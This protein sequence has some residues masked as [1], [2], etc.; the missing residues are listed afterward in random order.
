MGCAITKSKSVPIALSLTISRSDINSSFSSQ[1][2]R[3]K[4]NILPRSSKDFWGT[5]PYYVL[6]NRLCHLFNEVKSKF[7]FQKIL[8]SV[9]MILN[10]V[11]EYFDDNEKEV[12]LDEFGSTWVSKYENSEFLLRIL[13]LEVDGKRVYVMEG[14]N[15]SHVLVKIKEIGYF[16]RKASASE[17]QNLTFS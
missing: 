12:K 10:D 11:L 8:T 1:S 5:N 15:R 7:T 2:L 6:S 14:V 13:G 16:S 4:S 9:Q 17:F 3:R